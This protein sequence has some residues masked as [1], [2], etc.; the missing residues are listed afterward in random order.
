MRADDFRRCLE[1]V[2]IRGM[3]RLWAIVRPD[4]PQPG[5]DSEIEATIHHART[6]A[7]SMRFRARA[8]SHRWL[9]DHGLPSGLADELKPRAER[10]YPAIVEGVAIAVSQLDGSKTPTDQLV[11]AAIVAAVEDIYATDLRRRPDPLL[12]K[13]RIME[14]RDRERARLLA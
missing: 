11:E 3:R 12:V 14:V 2:D 10:V 9:L 13:A 7:Q 4:L 6:Q 5:S 8:W 1:E